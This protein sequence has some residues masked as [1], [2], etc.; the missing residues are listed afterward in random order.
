VARGYLPPDELHLFYSKR[1][2]SC[3]AKREWQDAEKAY[4]ASGEVDMAV[5]MYKVNKMWLPMLKLVQQHRREQLPQMHLLVAHVSPVRA[6]ESYS[7]CRPNAN[8][9]PEL[10]ILIAWVRCAAAAGWWLL[11]QQIKTF[12]W[13][14]WSC[15]CAACVQ[16]PA[17]PASRR[18]VA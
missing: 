11:L 14:D 12:S 5:N 10:F 16:H 2:R 3:E 1:A 6:A 18:L 7:G 8:T 9:G 17:G 4:V 15:D 13:R